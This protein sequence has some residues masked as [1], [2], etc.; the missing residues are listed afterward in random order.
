MVDNFSMLIAMHFQD[1]NATK[2]P[3]NAELEVSV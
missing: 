2:R 3:V 1:E